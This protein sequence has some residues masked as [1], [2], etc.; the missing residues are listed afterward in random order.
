MNLQ[1]GLAAIALFVGFTTPGQ[2]SLDG[3]WKG[4]TSQNRDITVKV[5]DGAIMS[6]KIGLHL[7]LSSPCARPGSPVA[8]DYRGGEAEASYSKPIPIVNGTFTVSSGVSDVDAKI[9]GKL[10]GDTFKGMIEMAAS[11]GSGCSGKATITWTATRSN[12]K[13]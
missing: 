4:Q 9:T 8:V 10:S 1:A 6:L 7:K 5:K 13:Q 12:Q 3:V 11:P 2:S